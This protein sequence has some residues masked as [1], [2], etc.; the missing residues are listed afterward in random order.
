MEYLSV[1][2]YADKLKI[3]EATVRERIKDGRLKADKMPGSNLWRIPLGEEE[4]KPAE[5]NLVELESEIRELEAKKKKLTLEQEIKVLSGEAVRGDE[6]KEREAEI[7]NKVQELEKISQSLSA[8][9]EELNKRLGDYK[10]RVEDLDLWQNQL[11]ET[12]EENS[13]LAK[14]LEKKAKDLEKR[15][16]DIKPQEEKI[17]A[18]KEELDRL[19]NQLESDRQ[20]FEAEKTKH[21]DKMR[22][23][24]KEVLALKDK[25]AGWVADYEANTNRNRNRIVKKIKEMWGED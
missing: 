22:L 2:E 4:V 12:E 16:N 9:E 8:R 13:K 15:N 10:Q 21:G 6:L 7:S 20:D 18:R 19:S 1:K 24:A 17:K 25:L 3:S 23:E 5:N 14:S 11:R